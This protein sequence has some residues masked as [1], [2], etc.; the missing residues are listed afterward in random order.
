MGKIKVRVKYQVLYDSYGNEYK[1]RLER[2]IMVE[3]EKPKTGYSQSGTTEKL[4]GTEPKPLK[5]RLGGVVSDHSSTEKVATVTFST[6]D[7]VA[8]MVS[9]LEHLPSLTRIRIYNYI[10]NQL[11]PVLLPLESVI[12]RRIVSHICESIEP[13][14]RLDALMVCYTA[15]DMQIQTK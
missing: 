15:A 11:T 3:E 2:K 13:A 6:A 4:I 9:E 7:M 10:Y 12:A 5:L 8:Y 14:Q 1:Y